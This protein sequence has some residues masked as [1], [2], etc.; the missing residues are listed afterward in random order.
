MIIDGPCFKRWISYIPQHRKDVYLYSTFIIV[1]LTLFIITNIIWSLLLDEPTNHLDS[2]T[3]GW[4]TDYLKGLTDTTVLVVSHDT[5]FL[6]NVCTDVIHYEKRDA[7]GP[8]RRLVHYAGKMSLFVEKQ[9]QSKHY[10]EL[11]TT[12]LKFIF[13]DPGRLDVSEIWTSLYCDVYCLWWLTNRGN[14]FLILYTCR[15]SKQVVKNSWKWMASIFVTLALKRIL[16]LE[17]S[18]RCPYLHELPC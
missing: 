4:L 6:E 18:W 5:P 10:F 2:V 16:L 8:Y 12:D 17:L 7:W 13:P 14:P 1:F 3:V 11:S 15:V 9:P